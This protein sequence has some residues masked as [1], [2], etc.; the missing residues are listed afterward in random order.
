MQANKFSQDIVNF[1]KQKEGFHPEMYLCPA[2]LPT[3]GYGLKLS[4]SSKYLKKGVTMT[5]AE[6]TGFLVQNIISFYD[7]IKRS[8]PGFAMVKPHERDAFL[9]LVYNLGFGYISQKKVYSK[10]KAGD[11]EGAAFEFLDIVKADGKVLRGLVIRRKEENYIF[12]NGWQAYYSAK[13]SGMF[14]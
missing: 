7:Q 1:I 4:S 3:I 10:F 5:E 9:S 14:R 11:I 13:R 2:G 8:W 6:A 12:L